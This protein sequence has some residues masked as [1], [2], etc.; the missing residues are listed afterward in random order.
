MLPVFFF[1][2]NLLISQD[3]LGYIRPSTNP[4]LPASYNFQEYVFAEPDDEGVCDGSTN[5]TARIEEVFF[6]QTHRHSTDHPFHFIIGHRPVLVQVAVIGS[7]NAPDVQI[8][9]FMNGQS[10]GTK[11]LSGPNNLPPSIALDAPNIED[12]FSVTIP[13]SWVKRGL[14]LEITVGNQSRFLDQATLKVGPYTEMNLVRVDQDYLDFN[15][16][17]HVRPEI[18]NFLAETASAIPASV[19]R[20]GVFPETIVYPEAIVANE[21]QQV[22]R[23]KNKA[24]KEA[25]GVPN[26]G[27]INA[28]AVVALSTMH[29]TTDDFLSTIYFGNTLNLAPGGWGGGGNFVSPDYDEVYIHELGHA[30]SLPHWGESAYDIDPEP[31]QYLFPY[32]GINNEGDGRGET[33]NFNQDTYEFVSPICG[34]DSGRGM[35]GEERSDCMQRNNFCLEERANGAGPW[36]GFSDFSAYAIHHNLIGTEGFSGTVP[37]RGTDSPWNIPY[38]E[39]YPIM[40]LE[41]GER[42]FTRNEGQLLKPNFRERTRIPGDVKLNTDVY[43]V[44]GTAHGSQQQGNIVYKPIKYN[45]TLLPLVDPTDPTTMQEMKTNLAYREMIRNGGPKDITLKMTYADGSTKHAIVPT[46]GYIRSED[47]NPYYGHFRFDLAHF[48]LV[49]P[50][51]KELTRV[52]LYRRHLFISDS[53]DSYSGNILDPNQ[54][55]TAENFMDEAE[56]VTEWGPNRPVSLGPNAIGN[57]VW[58]DANKNGIDDNGEQGIAGV[59]VALWGDNDGDGVPD[60]QSWKGFVTTDENGYYRFEGLEPGPYTVFVWQV[61]NWEEGGP[62]NGMIPTPNFTDA[63][64]D[65]DQDNNG[66]GTAGSDLFSGTII[67]TADGEP[68]NDGDP[69]DDWYNLDPAGNMTVDFGFYCPSACTDFDGDSYGVD[70]DC[71]DNNSTINP[72]NT[73]IV[74]NGIDDDCNPATLDDDLDRDG[75]GIA[76]DCNDNNAAINPSMIEITNSGFDE[77]CDGLS[78]IIDND[79]DGYN[80]SIDCDDNN[81]NINDRAVE[82]PNNG[83]DEDCDG[84]DLILEIDNDGDGF[85]AQVDCNDDDPAINPLAVEIP[86]NEVDENCDGEFTTS[87][88]EQQ[89]AKQLEVFPNPTTGI[90]YLKDND[91]LSNS[92]QIVVK[93]HLGKTVIEHQITRSSVMMI[94]FQPFH[95]GLFLLQIYTDYGVISKKVLVVK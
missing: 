43:L 60:S 24:G 44:Y 47:Y 92:F 54:N 74:Y 86:G 33:W 75:F 51:D 32:G 46:H 67:I 25:A 49:V 22:A 14:E 73:E 28:A 50:A 79:K 68:L 26:D 3:R 5:T 30:L 61:D 89:I 57:R 36:D 38:H 55:I 77:N 78:L 11:C 72:G 66:R 84:S 20:Y 53:F 48:S 39:G 95:T 65:I 15:I 2:S 88:I 93:D 6:A 23:L 16:E 21:T 1:L 58:Y 45:G 62:L 9:G 31:W 91:Y 76:V 42:T 69:E 41:N 52:E 19:I 34:I 71:N 80:S 12:Y 29:V 83:I 35:L 7:G 27:Y 70:V 13:K 17:P 94:N 82:V 40:K 64:N 37:Y 56:Y 59:K 87:T 90:I 4:A 85:T 8:E 10:I 18:N 63:N 81:A